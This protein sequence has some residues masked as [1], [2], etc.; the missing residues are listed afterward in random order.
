MLTSPDNPL[1]LHLLRDDIQNELFHHFSMDGD[2]AD[3]PVKVRE[4]ALGWIRKRNLTR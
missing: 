4:S 2:E 3:W 1:F